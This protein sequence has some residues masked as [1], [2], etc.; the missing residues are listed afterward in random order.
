[1]SND[2]QVQDAVVAIYANVKSNIVAG[3]FGVSTLMILLPR[4]MEAAGKYQN[5]DGTS[6]KNVVIGV[7]DRIIADNVANPDLAASLQQ[8]VPTACDI[9]YDC[10]KNR[11]VFAQKVQDAT[12]GCI[13]KCRK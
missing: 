13:A 8:L 3:Q 10:W 11:Y 1:M 7:V 6:K 2:S 12:Q 9:L 4:L 5:L